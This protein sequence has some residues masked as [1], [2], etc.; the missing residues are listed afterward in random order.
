VN[1]PHTAP[2]MKIEKASDLP[3]NTMFSRVGPA[4]PRR[5]PLPLGIR[6]L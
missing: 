5:A 2:P 4:Q 3:P 1:K 6:P